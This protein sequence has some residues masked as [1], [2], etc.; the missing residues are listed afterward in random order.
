MEAKENK[1]TDWMPIKG[2]D[3][4]VVNENGEVM[5]LKRGRLLTV[6]YGKRIKMCVKGKEYLTSAPH[7]LYAAI[8]GIDP[9]EIGRDFIIIN[10]GRKLSVRTLKVI[11][12][13]DILGIYNRKGTFQSPYANREE[14]YSVI[15]SF[16]TCAKNLDVEGM[17]KIFNKVKPKIMKTI[18]RFVKS[19]EDKESHFQHLCAYIIDGIVEGRYIVPEPARYA[20]R[21]FKSRIANRSI[22]SLLP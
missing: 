19:E 11:Q 17:W 13:R 8:H 4:Y 1:N 14:E 22:E 6:S 5:N 12:R 3:G 15:I 10:T 9:R 7:V 18:E 2:F 21:M 16:S 20:R